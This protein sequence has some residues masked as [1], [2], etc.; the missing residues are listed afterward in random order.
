MNNMFQNWKKLKEFSDISNWNIK[1]VKN[2]YEM[3]D[4]FSEDKNVKKPDWWI[5][6]TKKEEE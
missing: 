5:N 4:N 1:N 3:F 2:F 6:T